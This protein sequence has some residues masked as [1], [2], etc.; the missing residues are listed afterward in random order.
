MKK[1]ERKAKVSCRSEEKKLVLFQ[2]AADQG[3]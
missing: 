3:W 2:G 1:E